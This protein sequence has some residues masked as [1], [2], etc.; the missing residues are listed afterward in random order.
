MQQIADDFREKDI[1]SLE[2]FDTKSILTVLQ[3]ATHMA[4]IATM[5]KP[6]TLLAGKIISL[7]FFE[8]S[9]RTFSSF[10]AAAKRIGA[11]TIEYQGMHVS[12]VAK[13]ESLSDTIKTFAS[14]SDAIIIRHPEVG[15]ATKAA[16]ASDIPIINAGDGI[17]EHPTQALLDCYT[18]HNHAGKL[19][20]LKVV[21]AG[22]MKNGRTVHSLLSA[23]SKFADNTVYLLSPESLQLSPTDKASYTENGLTIHEIFHEKDLPKDADVWY[24]TRVQ[25]ERFSSDE[26]YEKMKHRFILNL[27]L[28]NTYGNSN[29]ILM[30]PL[31]RVGEIATD[32]DADPRAVYLTEQ[33]RNGMY[34]RMALLALLFGEEV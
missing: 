30:H 2:Q 8:P 3:Q 11:Q 6:T 5:A 12:S 28:L 13:G 19:D 15:T 4:D 16:E 18:I 22:D 34:V 31:P 32:V 21:C 29:L 10:A 33:M 24:W 26:E 9:S 14:Y 27:D 1:L 17:G 23:L 25:K 20:K 7:L